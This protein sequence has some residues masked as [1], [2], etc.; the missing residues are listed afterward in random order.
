MRGRPFELGNKIGPG[1]PPGSRN[2][3]TLFMEQMV[4]HGPAIIKQC[5]VMALEKDPTAMRICM[6]RLVPPCKPA[7]HRFRLPRG[8]TPADLVKAVSAINQQV[9]RGNLSA[10]EGE[11]M[12]RIIEIQ[13]RAIET[14]DFERRLQAQEKEMAKLRRPGRG[15][16]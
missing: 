5:Q 1:R 9:A 4:E 2:K 16:K 8:D 11:A 6:D 14:E 7:H 3:R 13:R 10:Q 12:A 15:H